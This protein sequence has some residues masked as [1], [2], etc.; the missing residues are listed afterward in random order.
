MSSFPHT[1]FPRSRSRVLAEL[2]DVRRHLRDA[3]PHHG[4]GLRDAL[5]RRLDRLERELRGV[6]DDDRGAGEVR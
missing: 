1:R 2:A 3:P 6:E 4:Q 5:Q